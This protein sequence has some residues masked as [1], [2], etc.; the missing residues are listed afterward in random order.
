MSF[1]IYKGR[2]ITNE[3][4]TG[5]IIN[6]TDFY[7]SVIND[8]CK[9]IGG[10]FKKEEQKEKGEFSLLYQWMISVKSNSLGT[11]N[12]INA[13]IKTPYAFTNDM[14]TPTEDNLLQIA[15]EGMNLVKDVLNQ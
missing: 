11:I 3:K 1:I 6:G 10:E 14:E 12:N 8:Y 4:G 15:K 5:I 9:I 13:I 7:G 2:P